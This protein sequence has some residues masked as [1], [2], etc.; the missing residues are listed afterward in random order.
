MFVY[1]LYYVNSAHNTSQC[2][3][4]TIDLFNVARRVER[5]NPAG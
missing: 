1:E 2:P 5:I 3:E 4:M